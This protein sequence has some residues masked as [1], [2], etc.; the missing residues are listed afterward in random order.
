MQISEYTSPD[1]WPF[2]GTSG[3]M[4]TYA[5]ATFVDVEGKI[6]WVGEPN[7]VDTPCYET[8]FTIN[9]RRVALPVVELP[10]TTVS[11]TIP[12][13]QWTSILFDESDTPR[14]YFLGGPYTT[15]SWLASPTTWDQVA[16]VNAGA[17]IT[18][19]TAYYLSA[20]E[21]AA[22]IAAAVTGANAPKASTIVYGS[23]T[24]NIPAADSSAPEVAGS[25]TPI[26]IGT[27]GIKAVANYANL[28]DA[29]ATI[30][31]EDTELYIN[32]PIVSDSCTVPDTLSL[33][34]VGDG[35]I[36]VNPGETVTISSKP[37]LTPGKQYFFG[38]GRV[39]FGAAAAIDGVNLGWWSVDNDDVTETLADAITSVDNCSGGIVT[40]PAGTYQLGDTVTVPDGVT[41]RGQGHTYDT[42]PSVTTIVVPASAPAFQ[43]NGAFRNIT[44]EN[45]RINGT[46]H[47]GQ[48]GI[49]ASGTQPD[50]AFGLICT[51]VVFN[52]LEVGIDIDASDHAWQVEEQVYTNC[53]FYNCV[54]AGYRCSSVN[55]S[56][57]FVAGNFGVPAGGVGIQANDIGATNLLGVKF[58]G[59]GKAIDINGA[60][61][62]FVINGCENEGNSLF[63]HN[64]LSDT[65]VAITFIGGFIQSPIKISGAVNVDL[66]GTALNAAGLFVI[67][68]GIAASIYA[69][70]CPGW[71]TCLTDNSGGNAIF[72]LTT[73]R[74]AAVISRQLTV[75]SEDPDTSIPIEQLGSAVVGKK[76]IRLG[77][78]NAT[79]KTFSSRYDL[80][81]DGN[82]YFF[83]DGN[84]AS[85]N[86]GLR[87]SGPI[88]LPMDAGVQPSGTQA[89]LAWSGTLLQLLTASTI[90][91]V[92]L[93]STLT[94][95]NRLLKATANGVLA[96][97]LL[98]DDGS[99]TLLTAGL[100]QFLGTSAS[101]P[102]IKRAGAGIAIRLAD[103]SADA[104]VSAANAIFSGNV[105]IGG[106]A[107]I[108]TSN[109]TGS[110]LLVK[111]TSPTLVTPTLGDAVASSV[112][113]SAAN[114]G[115]V[116]GLQRVAVITVDY[117]LAGKQNIFTIPAGKSGITFYVV[118]R[119]ASASLTTASISFGYDAN[120][121]DVITNATHTEITGS[122]VQTVLL[123]KAGAV[124]G[125]A[126][127]I[128]GMKANTLQGS[129]ATG[130]VELWQEIY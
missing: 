94:T 86:N 70:G 91:N 97:A 36:T 26:I 63:L 17:N 129:A 77:Q 111:Q 4:R 14:V 29:V 87:T 27:D 39:V 7:S 114:G 20:S 72:P 73:S 88:E 89:R 121:S 66:F 54:A 15:P 6:V 124:I 90:Y 44:F 37:N 122:T 45:L 2:G 34:F 96:S 35:S 106:G 75:F 8:P 40:I 33:Q 78:W 56:N 80:Y 107:A 113:I 118:L 93:A 38:G 81:R 68:S 24:L 57:V 55:T 9:D 23:V 85:P 127:A 5:N 28:A 16:I 104:G 19:P 99:N 126:G 12:T 47:T 92:L 10:D 128:F 76:F 49:L 102:A 22:L 13:T 52:N 82:G 60:I 69:V 123:A 51:N 31:S 41:I 74:T 42:S 101:F 116:I 48:I 120:A 61:T 95:T 67:D 1:I 65:S 62:S 100:L 64:H 25:N 18:W 105:T 110:G 59:E 98:S 21:T 30:G 83:V 32:S 112:S 46:P 117:N 103:D 53:Q 3:I 71:P 11:P 125:T 130:V 109:A 43:C 84:Q 108:T 58:G 115:G 119:G 50:S 79:T